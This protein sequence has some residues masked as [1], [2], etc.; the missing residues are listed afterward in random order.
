MTSYKSHPRLPLN[1]LLLSLLALLLDCIITHSYL[2]SYTPARLL[3]T[4]NNDNAWS[5]PFIH[6]ATVDRSTAWKLRGVHPLTENPKNQAILLV[7]HGYITIT[8][9][10]IVEQSRERQ[11]R[12]PAK[13]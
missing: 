3:V 13:G 4:C 6:Q 11:Q 2:S 1:N 10:G 7:S 5:L 8:Y 9:E 12:P